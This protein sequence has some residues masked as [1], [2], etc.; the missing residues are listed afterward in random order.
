MGGLIGL[1]FEKYGEKI[2]NF[3]DRYFNLLAVAFVIL[4]ILG[5]M[6][7]SLMGKD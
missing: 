6:A 5:F 2:K 3:I 4:L 1:L 7:L